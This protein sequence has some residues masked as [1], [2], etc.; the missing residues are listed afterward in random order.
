M[1]YTSSDAGQRR[2]L[3]RPSVSIQ[4]HTDARAR[5][6]G[7]TQR[8]GLRSPSLSCESKAVDQPPLVAPPP[9]SDL[10]PSWLLSRQSLSFHSAPVRLHMRMNEHTDVWMN[11]SFRS[12]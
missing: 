2:A 5:H 7:N 10:S 3:A 1:K 12:V 6:R 11:V 9:R 4:S 8:R